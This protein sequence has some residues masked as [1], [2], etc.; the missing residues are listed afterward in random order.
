MW[1][2]GRFAQSSR[3]HSAANPW[4]QG[5]PDELPPVGLFPKLLYEKLFQTE[6]QKYFPEV[7]YRRGAS[8]RAYS[9]IEIYQKARQNL[10]FECSNSRSLGATTPG[11]HPPYIPGTDQKIFFSGIPTYV[12]I[13]AVNCCWGPFIKI[14]FYDTE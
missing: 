12:R 7:V 13:P 8:K 11:G 10:I 2:Q 4:L 9:T 3:D 5:N 1:C 6:F 14:T